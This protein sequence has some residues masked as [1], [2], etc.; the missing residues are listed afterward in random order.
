VEVIAMQIV[1][2]AA[3]S[4][5]VILVAALLLPGLAMLVLAVACWCVAVKGAHTSPE[6][7]EYRLAVLD[8]LA[9][10]VAAVRGAA[11]AR[12]R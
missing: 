2:A 8:R 5:G 7:R 11:G 3:G 6:E 1:A 10:V 9:L 4:Y 12:P